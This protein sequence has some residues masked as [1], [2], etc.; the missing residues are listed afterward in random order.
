MLGA[1]YSIALMRVS[2]GWKWALVVGLL[3]MYVWRW[4][5]V[6]KQ[7]CAGGGFV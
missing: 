7:R 6:G 4:L 1:L 5:G 2:V 3:V